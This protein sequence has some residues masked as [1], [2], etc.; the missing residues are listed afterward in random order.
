MFVADFETRNQIPASVWCAGIMDVDDSTWEW[1]NNLEDFMTH[2]FTL[3]DIVYFH[4]LAFDGNFIISYLLM[5]GWEYSESRI[6]HTFNTIIDSMGNYFAI[7]IVVDSK[8][9]Q[10]K[11]GKIS[12]HTNSIKLYD[13][14]KLLPFS[15]CEIA[16]GFGLEVTKGEINYNIN[17]PLDYIP[18][19]EEL[20][21]IYRD[22]KIIVDALKITHDMGINKI[23]IGSSAITDWKYRTFGE[24]LE[25]MLPFYRIRRIE[26]N[27]RKAF[28][29]LPVEIDSF[30]RKAYKGGYCYVN[31][32]FQNIRGNKGLVF[33]VNSLYPSRMR[34]EL[35]PYGMPNY[36][37]GKYKDDEGF[38][39]YV[40][41]IKADFE[42]KENY[43]PTIQIKNHCRFNS[44][45]YISDTR[46][47]EIDLFLTNVDLEL[48]LEHYTV[49][50]IEYIEGFKFRGKRGFFD[51]YIDYW[52]E[53]KI[54]ATKE[55]NKALRQLAKLML[56]NVYG[57]FGTRIERQS[58]IPYLD[59]EEVVRLELNAEVEVIE[60]LSIAMAS[61]ITA[62]ARKVTI[63]EA[64]KNYKR[65]MYADTDS[66]HLKGFRLPKLDIDNT[67]LGAWALEGKFNDSIY[68]KAKTYGENM[69]NDKTANWEVDIKCAGLSKSSIK[70]IKTLDDF[71][72]GKQLTKL[73][74]KTVK[75][76]VILFDDIHTI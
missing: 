63:T 19:V 5:N 69:W 30:I 35:L 46:G 10:K 75:G 2:L 31:P 59:S 38:P 33:D 34:I 62:Y 13:S 76:G 45:E 66:L 20:D 48:F 11:N 36:Y 18:T 73:K 7:E 64:Q 22:L 4:N 26:S 60:G 17:R 25:D 57:K 68:I 28:P 47:E 61:F 50:T 9:I 44:T 54:R 8:K 49:H 14:L 43:L 56:N 32:K 12:T 58:K 6:T 67:N 27:F 42:I 24:G 16:K 52:T 21:Y 37:V 71:Y 41:H 23:T 65:F 51:A 15:A 74:K 70:Q 39:L 3:N 53:I 55:G 1:W 40:Q 29:V 72:K